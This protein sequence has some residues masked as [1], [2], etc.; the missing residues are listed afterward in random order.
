MN[1]VCNLAYQLAAVILSEMMSEL[2]R[3]VLSLLTK[4]SRLLSSLVIFED[5][6][7]LSG[8][9]A[10]YCG[11]HGASRKANG[12]LLS[13]T[14]YMTED[15]GGLRLLVGLRVVLLMIVWQRI[16]SACCSSAS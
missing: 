8:M 2:A 6:R 13:I 7:Y 12:H 1:H 3:V 16:L 14:A 9:I 5:L 4:L 10:Q 15:A 11:G